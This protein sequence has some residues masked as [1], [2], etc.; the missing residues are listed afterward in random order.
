MNLTL[1][2]VLDLRAFIGID[3]LALEAA[4]RFKELTVTGD[5]WT[6]P[7]GAAGRFVNEVEP[8]LGTNWKDVDFQ[9]DKVAFPLRPV[10]GGGVKL[11]APSGSTLVEHLRR[12][13][14]D[15]LRRGDEWGAWN[16]IDLAR[17]E[18]VDATRITFDRDTVLAYVKAATIA[19]SFWIIPPG[20]IEVI[21]EIEH[22]ADDFRYYWY[23]ITYLIEFSTYSVRSAEDCLFGKG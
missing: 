15:V 16:Y 17:T 13:A 19:M 3:N 5:S 18:Q 1:L 8:A 2:G 9:V 12:M 23:S 22:P 7:T 20:Y 11:R 6:C 10:F 4:P 21:I 14:I